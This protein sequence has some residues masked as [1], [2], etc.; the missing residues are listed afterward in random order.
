MVLCAAFGCNNRTDT[1]KFKAVESETNGAASSVV[2]T[3]DL[4]HQPADS[5]SESYDQITE[6]KDRLNHLHEKVSFHPFPKEGPLR[7]KWIASFNR[8]KR[9]IA[10][11]AQLC[12]THFRPEC[13]EESY[14]LKVC[15]LYYQ[16]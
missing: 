15:T 11:S 10:K 2:P 1:G 9:F 7:D 6:K 5:V 13:Y 14:W 8:E 16:S 3:P 4:L 12:S